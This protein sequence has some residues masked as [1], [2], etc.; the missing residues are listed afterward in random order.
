LYWRAPIVLRVGSQRWRCWPREIETTQARVASTSPGKKNKRHEG[1][2]EQS[3]WRWQGSYDEDRR[4]AGGERGAG[5]GDHASGRYI[6]AQGIWICEKVRW[7]RI[8]ASV[9]RTKLTFFPFRVWHTTY[10][11][12]SNARAHKMQ[13]VK[14]LPLLS[15]TPMLKREVCTL[16]SY[17]SVLHFLH[18]R[19]YCDLTPLC[20]FVSL[21]LSIL[22]SVYLYISVSVYLCISVSFS[23]HIPYTVCIYRLCSNRSCNCAASSLTSR[24]QRATPGGRN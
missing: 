17:T 22:V 3:V 19:M 1:I 21:L 2:S 18:A 5:G 14:E 6:A 4:G 8:C 9:H 20:I 16:Y 15:E 10:R 11:R 23:P 13:V 12:S 7:R 24:T